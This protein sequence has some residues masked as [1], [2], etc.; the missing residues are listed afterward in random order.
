MLIVGIILANACIWSSD[1]K[2]YL[3]GMGG[4]FTQY[5]TV[6][7][8]GSKHSGEDIVL[9]PMNK[10]KLWVKLRYGVDL[11]FDPCFSSMIAV[12]KM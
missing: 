6:C 12:M 8:D 4:H 1:G 10:A 11:V 9:L 7:K 2:F 5:A 3:H